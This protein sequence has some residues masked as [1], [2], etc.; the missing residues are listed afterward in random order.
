MAWQCPWHKNN[1]S[2]TQHLKIYLVAQEGPVHV[3]RMLQLA[4]SKLK[5]SDS[6]IRWAL[7]PTWDVFTNHT[8]W[9][10]F[11][12]F[13]CG[14]SRSQ[15]V[16]T[17]LAQRSQL[18][19][20]VWSRIPKPQTFVH[21]AKKTHTHT[22]PNPRNLL[23][24]NIVGNCPVFSSPSA[25]LCAFQ[26]RWNEPDVNMPWQL[27]AHT[28]KLF[29]LLFPLFLHSGFLQKYVKPSDSHL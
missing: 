9:G 20:R 18:V 15:S 8:K 21:L 26:P 2:S 25:A 5:R 23:F 28:A 29:S 14:S 11:W 19:N 27:L 16:A 3:F 4:W 1:Q 22:P 24:L 10:L 13:L 12:L 17:G 7:K 6:K